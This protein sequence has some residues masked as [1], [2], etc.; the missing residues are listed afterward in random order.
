[1]F[2]TSIKRNHRK[3]RRKFRAQAAQLILLSDAFNKMRRVSAEARV[4][5][6]GRPQLTMARG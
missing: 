2:M 5:Q 6:D 3:A 1:M 4:A